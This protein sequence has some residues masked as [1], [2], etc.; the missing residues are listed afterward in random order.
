M[1]LPKN[2]STGELM[3]YLTHRIGLS[4]LGYGGSQLISLDI[5]MAF[6]RV[7]DK[8]LLFKLVS[9]GLPSSLVS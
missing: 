7:F 9:F 6:D 1:W 4:I 8:V 3:T 2:R 5:A